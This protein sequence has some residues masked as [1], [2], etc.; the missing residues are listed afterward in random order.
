VSSNDHP[1]PPP[2]AQVTVRAAG[3]GDAGEIL[4]LQRAAYLVEAQAYG[5]PFIPPLV[6]TLAEVREQ[7]R[8][9]TVLV[10]TT[11]HR[12]VAAVRLEVSG[13]TGRIGRLAVVP[14]LQGQGLGARMLLAAEQAAPAEVTR[15]E[16]FTG[17]AS[18][19][20]LALYTHRGY[21]EFDRQRLNESVELVHLRR[22]R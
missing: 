7:I 20:N 12:L 3:D 9:V 6:E 17:A 19:R 22:P 18:T 1:G 13:S 11:G 8:T 10:A 2:A 16:L 4:T 14:D 5:D 15:F 21:V